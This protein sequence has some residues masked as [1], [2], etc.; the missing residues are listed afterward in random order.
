MRLKR[1]LHSHSYSSNWNAFDGKICFEWNLNG[2]SE[3]S[4]TIA[5]SI[6]IRSLWKEIISIFDDC[7]CWNEVKSIWLSCTF[8][9]IFLFTFVVL[10][11][12]LK[13]LINISIFGM[14]CLCVCVCSVCSVVNDSNIIAFTIN[15]LNYLSSTISCICIHSQHKSSISVNSC[16][17]Q[18]MIVCTCVCYRS[19]Q[20]FRIDQYLFQNASKCC[21]FPLC[22]I[23]INRISIESLI[24][25]SIVIKCNHRF[26]HCH[27]R[28]S[29]LCI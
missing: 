22:K 9:Q 24:R 29:Q 5:D 14:S 10:D 17:T 16:S 7:G 21:Q 4:I 6:R 25:L 18:C 20:T 26:Q 13:I 12:E 2:C 8:T 28:A 23:I 27:C 19:Q 3:Q 11:E 15:A 1:C